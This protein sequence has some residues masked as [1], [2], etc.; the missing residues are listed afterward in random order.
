MT[1]ATQSLPPGLVRG[2]LSG[3]L[4]QCAAGAAIVAAMVVWLRI[5]GRPLVCDCGTIALWDG[6]ARSPG[7]SQQFADWYSALHL[8]FGMA[9]FVF[10]DRMRPHWPTSWKLLAALASSAVWEGA[11]NTP[12]IIALFGAPEGAPA[13]DGDSILNALGD[14]LFVAA[15]FLTA[16][17]LPLPATIGVAILLEIAISVAISDGFVIGTLRLFGVPV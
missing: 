12:M 7:A 17:T 2:F 3:P 10:L 14:T 9:L 8:I 11:E 15:G 1:N 13:Y 5:M 16:R 6:D 4:G